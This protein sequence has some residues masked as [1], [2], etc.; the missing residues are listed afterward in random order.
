MAIQFRISKLVI[1]LVFRSSQRIYDRSL[2]IQSFVFAGYLDLLYDA[3]KIQPA[4]TDLSDSLDFDVDFH[5]DYSA[6]GAAVGSAASSR[7]H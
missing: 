5:G 7:D 4:N 1:G 2:K 3:D 6:D